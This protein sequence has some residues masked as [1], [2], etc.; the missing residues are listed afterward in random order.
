MEIADRFSKYFTNTGSN[1][2]RST[3]SVNPS[4]RFYLGANIHPS[5]N[6]KPTTTCEQESICSMF[7]SKAPGYDS[8]S[9]YVIKHSL[10]PISA[11][12]PDIINLLLLKG[13]FLD[14]LK[15]AK[16]IPIHKAEDPSLFV[17]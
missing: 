1:L 13:I 7:T 16:I 10:H 5:I 14:K 11:P 17:N 4:F 6:L 3:P 8:I 9:V 15:I 12:L 2:T